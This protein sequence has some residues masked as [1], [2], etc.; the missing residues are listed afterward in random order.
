MWKTCPRQLN[1]SY[2]AFKIHRHQ[3]NRHVASGEGDSDSEENLIELWFYQEIF[4]MYDLKKMFFLFK[5][6]VFFI[7]T[8]EMVLKH[9]KMFYAAKISFPKTTVT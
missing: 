6:Y 9:D 4:E 5:Y 3:K 2:D 7:K 1:T 8:F